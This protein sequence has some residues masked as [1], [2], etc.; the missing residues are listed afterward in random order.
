VRIDVTSLV[1]EWPQRRADD[2]GVALLVH[3]DDR[4][5]STFTMGITGGAGPRLEAYVR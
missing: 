4:V 5:G 1:R 3:G 2:H